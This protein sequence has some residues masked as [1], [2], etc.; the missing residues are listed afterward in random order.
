MSDINNIAFRDYIPSTF[1]TPSRSYTV[2]IICMYSDLSLVNKLINYCK[3]LSVALYN[4]SN[5]P[6]GGIVQV[7]NLALSSIK[8]DF[9]LFCHHDVFGSIRDFIS[10]CLKFSPNPNIYG[11]VGKSFSNNT[12]WTN[13]KQPTEISTLDECLFGFFSNHG[14]S[15]DPK[16]TWTNY[17]QEISCLSRSMGGKT[18]VI[19]NN[20]QH[21]PGIHHSFF[22]KSGFFNKELAYVHKKWGAF[23]RT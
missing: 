22:T 23:Y 18:F 3:P 6:P 8:A 13:V 5:P 15:F 7:Y 10:L 12:L 11:C 16:L 1:S 17:S 4:G 21:S 9:F 19:P 20:I 2:A 14:L